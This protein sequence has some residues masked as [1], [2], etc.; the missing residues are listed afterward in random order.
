MGQKRIKVV[1]ET[2]DAKSKKSKPDKKRTGKVP[3]LKGGQRVVMVSSESP[4]EQKK[5]AAEKELG[6]EATSPKE[7]PL[8]KKGQPARGKPY[9]QAK[10]RLQQGR[11]YPLS[12][13]LDKIKEAKV[14]RFD[15]TVEAHLTLSKGEKSVRG[16][17]KLPHG[18]GKK[19][20]VLVFGSS[21]KADIVGS[22]EVLV[23][24]GAGKVPRVDLVLATAEW[25]P[26]LAK[27][28]K[29]LGPKGLMPNPKTGTV[30]EEPDKV[31]QE[32]Q[33]GAVTYRTD[34]SSP[35]IHLGIGKVSWERKKLEENLTT[36]INAVGSQRVVKLSL[37]S[38]MG[39][40]VKIQLP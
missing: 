30:T 25:M 7:R 33:D 3:G 38:T 34:P 37:S 36:L 28:A 11:L 17:V 39:P 8:K 31:I 1:S 9:Q 16:K 21:T 14:T 19:A 18:T 10:T 23:E 12:E 15:G 24:I 40:G 26:K 5:P 32:V 35:V 29:F 13:A 27:V 6:L 22:D 20:T 2:A 4:A